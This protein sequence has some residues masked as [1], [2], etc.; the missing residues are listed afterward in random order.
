MFVAVGSSA[1]SHG[2]QGLEAMQNL[3]KIMAIR[4]QYE[5]EAA[6]KSCGYAVTYDRDQRGSDGE[7]ASEDDLAMFRGLQ[8]RT[9]EVQQGHPVMIFCGNSSDHGACQSGRHEELVHFEP[10]TEINVSQSLLWQDDQRAHD[11]W[12]GKYTPEEIAKWNKYKEREQAR[13][14]RK[15]QRKI[16]AR[17][18]EWQEWE[19]QRAAEQRREAPE[20]VMEGDTLRGVWKEDQGQEER[21]E[22][23]I[24]L[25]EK[26]FEE[27]EVGSGEKEYKENDPSGS[28]HGDRDQGETPMMEEEKLLEEGPIC[29]VGQAWEKGQLPATLTILEK[30]QIYV[31][32]GDFKN[33]EKKAW[34]AYQYMRLLQFQFIGEGKGPT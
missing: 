27:P 10:Y 13:R 20:E 16:D 32:R 25:V 24:R 3:S 14:Q 22:G 6:L 5:Y 23:G 4:D 19:S 18:K 12:Q 9:V 1:K 29:R 8:G 17:E 15:R 31:Y 21:C 28:G 11:E 2:L 26:E 30:V 7:P 34:S 33:Q